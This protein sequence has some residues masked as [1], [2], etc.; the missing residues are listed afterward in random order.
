MFV[1][2]SALL[3]KYEASSVCVGVFADAHDHRWIVILP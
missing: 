1:L 3:H 2:L